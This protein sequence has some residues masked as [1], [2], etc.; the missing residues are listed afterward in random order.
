[1]NQSQNN[2]AVVPRIIKYS[3]L[4][5]WFCAQMIQLRIGLAD[6]G[7]W[8]RLGGWISSG[9]IGFKEGWI[10]WGDPEYFNRYFT[11]WLPVWR[12]DYPNLGSIFS[13]SLLLWTPGLILNNLLASRE[14]LYLSWISFLPRLMILIFI[15]ALFNWVDRFT[16]KR[17]L[18][19]LTLV[20]PLAIITSTTDYVAYFNTFYQETA[21]FVG[22]IYL[23][24]S[25][26]AFRHFPSVK[27]YIF[28]LASLVLLTL[29][30]ASA[31]YWPIITAPYILLSG[32]SMKLRFSYFIITSL[33]LIVLPFVSFKVTSNQA[34]RAM[35]F[36]N[37]FYTGILPFSKNSTQILRELSIEN[38]ADCIDNIDYY[39]AARTSCI[40]TLSTNVDR[41]STF[42]LYL[43]EPGIVIKQL[44]YGM[45]QLQQLGLR[46]SDYFAYNLGNYPPGV[47]AFPGS[48]ILNLWST[49]KSR[50]FP[51]NGAALVSWLVFFLA[52]IFFLRFP[53]WISHISSLG[54]VLAAALILEILVVING[55]GKY[56]IV[57]HLYLANL[58]FD[59][60]V[61]MV[62]NL[63]LLKYVDRLEIDNR[64]IQVSSQ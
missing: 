27:N 33:F 34:M 23:L 52:F 53:G 3:I 47:T 26:L 1:M 20:L 30:K 41:E 8:I 15:L 28:F 64:R 50:W 42:D 2:P 36:F 4:L 14:F 61:I 10:N 21:A 13:S 22:L 18:F 17:A 25:L 37:T 12:L 49:L 44:G 38:T 7:D 51:R 46:G 57:K 45:T 39:S 35:N 62:V 29:S 48:A 11:Y 19:Y 40:T 58:I 9:P 6:N 59:L 16:Q 56:E 32:K 31:F 63:F 43:N 5:L 54:I 24:W 55:D 60:S